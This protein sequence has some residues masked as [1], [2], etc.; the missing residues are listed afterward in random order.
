MVYNFD[1]EETELIALSAPVTLLK[2]HKI[3]I[4]IAQQELERKNKDYVR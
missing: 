2:V 1:E 4:R 3:W